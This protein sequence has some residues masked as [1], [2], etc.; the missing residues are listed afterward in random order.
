[1]ERKPGSTFDAKLLANCSRNYD[2]ALAADF[3]DVL[4]EGFH[5]LEFVRQ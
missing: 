2:L 4:F 5:G 1:M 3:G